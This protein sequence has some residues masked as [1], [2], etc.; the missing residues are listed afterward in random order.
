MTENNLQLISFLK[1]IVVTL[2]SLL[3]GMGGISGKYKRRHLAPLVFLSGVCLF[4]YWQASFNW[5]YMSSLIIIAP[6]SM[7][8]GINSHLVRYTGS[9]ITARFIVGILIGLATMS[10]AIINQSYMLLGMH[11]FVCAFMS[12]LLGSFNPTKSARAEESIIGFT[13][14]FLPMFYF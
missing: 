8:Y 13:Y 5:W 10:I 7:G 4:S 3:Y 1:I 9:K 6:L 14:F 11:I 2:C 12:T